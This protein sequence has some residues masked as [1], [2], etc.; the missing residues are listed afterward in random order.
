MSSMD[1]W[2]AAIDVSNVC[3]SPHLPPGGKRR[4]VWA[5]LALVM[6]AWRELHGQDARFRLVADD[7]LARVVDDP[8]E[9]F[10][11]RDRGELLTA[12]IAD[13][14]ILTLARDEGLHVI[15]RDF[16][17]D[18]RAAHPWIERSPERFH[19][20]DTEG[21]QVTITPLPVTPVSM[22]QV[23]MAIELKVL[24]RTRLD[25]K[26]PAHRR[27]LH[28]RWR[29]GNTSCA[30]AASWQGQLMSWPAASPAGEARC[31][32]C[33]TPLIALGP[34]PLLHEVVVAVHDSGQEITRFPVE[35]DVPVIVGRGQG[36]SGI[37][38]G[39]GTPLD[40]SAR[41]AAVLR[42]SRAHL[43]LHLEEL[44]SENWRLSAMDLDSTNGTC[45]ER[46]NG[47]GFSP[48]QPLP[49]GRRTV[50]SARDR[51]IL[52]GAVRLRLSGKRHTLE[53]A[54][55]PPAR[56]AAAPPPQTVTDRMTLPAPQPD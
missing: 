5:R 51:L 37:D 35:A 32:S 36:A 44:G 55:P 14:L 16:Y 27:I 41:T 30:Q 52:G 53:A 20:W 42:V 13:S 31:P 11:L 6:A 15:T 43:L 2:N 7:S 22:Q 45:L 39:M 10:R 23:S 4:P 48:P 8:R 56:D 24:R 46:W 12:P 19:G 1:G 38:L 29:C 21:G 25:P 3:W 9:L 40:G 54:A 28:T 17:V 26:N 49:G 47:S 33:G 50:I 34:R 18:H